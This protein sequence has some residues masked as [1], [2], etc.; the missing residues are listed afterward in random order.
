MRPIGPMPPS[1]KAGPEAELRRLLRDPAPHVRAL[2]AR[3]VAKLDLGC[4]RPEL[5][6]LH[7]ACV[8]SSKSCT[9]IPTPW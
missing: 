5:E 7:A 6:E 1:G 4:L 2:A 3:L 9:A 8:P